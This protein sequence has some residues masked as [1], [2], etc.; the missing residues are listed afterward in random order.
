MIVPELVAVG[1]RITAQGENDTRQAVLDLQAITATALPRIVMQGSGGTGQSIPASTLTSLTG[2]SAGWAYIVN[3][4]GVDLVGNPGVNTS[5][6]TIKEP[7]LYLVSFRISHQGLA[8]GRALTDV[9]LSGGV[10][11]SQR[12]NWSLDDSP[13]ATFLVQVDTT[14]DVQVSLEDYCA[15][16]NAVSSATPPRIT[17]IKL[18]S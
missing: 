6:I 4:G 10:S 17:C 9:R 5:P 2:N 16:A 13:A 11:E 8:G 18:R 14:T 15:G 12:T 7:G 1:Q 3:A